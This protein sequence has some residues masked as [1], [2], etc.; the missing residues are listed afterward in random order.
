M[1]VRHWAQGFVVLSDELITASFLSHRFMALR[2]R[3]GEGGGREDTL[4]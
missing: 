1:A 4:S 3:M 2:E